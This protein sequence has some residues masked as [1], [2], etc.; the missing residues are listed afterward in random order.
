MPLTPAAERSQ[1]ACTHA[2]THTHTHVR[3]HNAV[4][5]IRRATIHKEPFAPATTTTTAPSPLLLYTKPCWEDDDCIFHGCFYFGQDLHIE[6]MAEA[7]FY[8]YLRLTGMLLSIP[9]RGVVRKR[10]KRRFYF[11]RYYCICLCR[12][13]RQYIRCT[14]G[15]HALR[16]G[17]TQMRSHS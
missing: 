14:K 17:P 16:C 4:A 13:L 11:C 12:F 2:H 6:Q 3:A 5:H 7:K 10:V 8:A 1:H 9:T 15:N